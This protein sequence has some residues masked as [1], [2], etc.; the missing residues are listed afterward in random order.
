MDV[1][2]YL[3]FVNCSHTHND[4]MCNLYVMYYAENGQKPYFM[5]S[6]NSFSNLF[7]DIPAD[8]DIPL[9]SNPWLDAVAAGHAHK[10]ISD[11]FVIWQHSVVYYVIIIIIIFIRHMT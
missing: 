7:D 9:P 1:L 4:E 6:S 10:G 3:Q 8:N 2:L 11:S 5:C